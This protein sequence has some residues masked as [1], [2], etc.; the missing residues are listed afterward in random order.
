MSVNITG[1]NGSGMT[2][3]VIPLHR[4]HYMVRT[5][6]ESIQQFYSPRN[7]FIIT[8]K[9]D[10]Q[11]IN[12]SDYSNV[13]VI[14]EE[15]F[16]MTNYHMTYLDIHDCFC[17]TSTGEMREF[18][19]WYQ[20]FI[21]LGAFM[22]IP[23]LS[24]P[25][26]VW[27]SDLISLEKWDIYPTEENP[28]FRFAILQE[29]PRNEWI[30]EQYAGSLYELTGLSI[31]D[32]EKGTFVPHHYVFHHHVLKDLLQMIESKDPSKKNWIERIM[33]ISHT[34]LRFSEYRAVS[35]F[36][37]VHYPNLLHYHPFEKY[38]ESGIRMREPRHFLEQMEQFFYDKDIDI[39]KGISYVDFVTFVNH[40]FHIN[41]ERKP[42]YLQIEHI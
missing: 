31:C 20:Q 39:S 19:W 21:K 29:M 3:F 23:N 33:E 9:M 30:M 26:I 22:Q 4:Y 28:H 17:K 15:N 5:V 41:G 1:L 35:S 25:Y 32:P 38:G 6:I 24:D 11:Q 37:K 27:D 18:G 40:I 10:C 2:D 13:H 14:E 7:I 16:F 12:C 8:P 36:M 42:S 34:Y